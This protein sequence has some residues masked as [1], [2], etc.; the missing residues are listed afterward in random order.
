[1][2]SCTNLTQY[3]DGPGSVETRV[4]GY[5]RV[6]A[7]VHGSVTFV[8]NTDEP[9][10]YQLE[11]YGNFTAGE[12]DNRLPNVRADQIDLTTATVSMLS[13]SEFLARDTI[14]IKRS[15][16]IHLSKRTRRCNRFSFT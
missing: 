5:G 2:I 15:E 7:E 3:L 10:P 12:S 11:V 16:F 8:G 4:D 6:W 9:L 14:F 13:Q 1:L